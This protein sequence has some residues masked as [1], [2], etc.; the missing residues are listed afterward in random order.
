M[1][2]T[3]VRICATAAVVLLASTVPSW[4]YL[5]PGTGSLLLQS[6]IAVI[7][8]TAATAGFYWSKT[9]DLVARLLHRR[10]HQE[11]KEVEKDL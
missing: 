3:S 8:A 4:A 1:R 6:A 5:D 2:S 7:A 9:R 11:G 10:G